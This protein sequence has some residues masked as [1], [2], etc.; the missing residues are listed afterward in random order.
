MQVKLDDL[1]DTATD[2][3]A[4]VAIA[5]LALNGVTNIEVVGTIA[6]L[7]G[8]RHRVRSKSRSGN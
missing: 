6:G 2:A 4:I 1:T 8:Y 5:F 7:A 3:L